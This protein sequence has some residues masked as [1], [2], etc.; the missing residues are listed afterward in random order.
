VLIY[1]LAAIVLIAS[2]LGLLLLLGSS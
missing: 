1:A 2:T